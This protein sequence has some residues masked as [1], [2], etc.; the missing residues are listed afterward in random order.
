METKKRKISALSI[1]SLVVSIFAVALYVFVFSLKWVAPIWI[2]CS[3]A[4]V[5]IPIISK[6]VRLNHNQSGKAFEIIALIIGGFAF[7][8]VIFASTNLPIFIGYLGWIV[9]GIVYALI[10][11]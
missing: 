11:K 4:S 1:I 2:I 5:V 10:K 7:Y 9:G 8:F 3:I 6:K